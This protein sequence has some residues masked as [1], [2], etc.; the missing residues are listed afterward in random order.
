[1]IVD[2]SSSDVT[3]TK[4]ISGVNANFLTKSIER[5]GLDPNNLQHK[6]EGIDFGKVCICV[7]SRCC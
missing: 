3:Y 5:A 7:V 6:H 1:M 4:E 2:S